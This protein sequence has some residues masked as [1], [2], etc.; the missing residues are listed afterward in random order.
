MAQHEILG[1]FERAHDDQW[2]YLTLDDPSP[3]SLDGFGSTRACVRIGGLIE[4][5]SAL[6]R[7]Q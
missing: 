4:T 1:S 5:P 7:V 2:H 3:L 6:Q